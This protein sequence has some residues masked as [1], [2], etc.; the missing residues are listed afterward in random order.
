MSWPVV[1]EVVIGLVFFFWLVS[2][3]ASAINEAIANLFRMRAHGLEKGIKSM[4]GDEHVE[5][6]FQTAIVL[7][8]RKPGTNRKPS[9]LDRSIFTDALQELFGVEGTSF[10]LDLSNVANDHLRTRL[11]QFAAKV[12]ND[13]TQFRKELETWFDNTMDRASGWYKRRSHLILFIIG[14]VV[15]G[16]ANMSPVTIGQRLWNDA[17]FRSI[18][19]A[20]AAD[21]IASATPTTT[22]ATPTTTTTTLLA[23]AGGVSPPA[24]QQSTTTTPPTPA[25]GPLQRAESEYRRI[26]QL[27]LPAGW[28]ADNQPKGAGWWAAI[29]GWLIT[30]FAVTLGAPFWFDVLNKVS[31]LRTAGPVTPPP[32]PGDASKAAD[33]KNGSTTASPSPPPVPSGPAITNRMKPAERA[34]VIVSATSISGKTNFSRLYRA[35]DVAGPTIATAQLR[36]TYAT[37]IPLTREQCTRARI[38]KALADAAANVAAVDLILMVHGE[39]DQ[40]ILSDGTQTGSEEVAAFDLAKDI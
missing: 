4:L 12:G 21:A 17:S 9:Y 36:N 27:N 29:L 18:V 32:A 38:V 3:L 6:F 16:V 2:V 25:P 15:A 40:L 34:I 20:E 28:G 23:P 5:T 10:R 39:P 35:L 24:T 7:S 14:L 37:I 31:R 22:S 33:I 26:H 1:V 30:A 13:A 11:E 8:Q 19:N